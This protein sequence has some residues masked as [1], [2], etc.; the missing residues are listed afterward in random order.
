MTRP[1]W[2]CPDG[3]RMPGP[4]GMPAAVRGYFSLEPTISSIS[5]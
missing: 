2:A 5:P 4:L 1:R 3:N